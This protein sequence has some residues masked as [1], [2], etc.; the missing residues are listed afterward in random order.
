MDLNEFNCYYLNPLLEKVAKEQKIVFFLLGDFNV[1]LL[2][3]KQHKAANEFVN[4]MSSNI[5]SCLRYP[6]IG[7]IFRTLIGWLMQ[8]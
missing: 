3:Y 2:K 5:R 6:T 7:K 1:D 8:S 4:S